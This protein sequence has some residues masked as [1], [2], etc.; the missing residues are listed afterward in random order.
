MERLLRVS[1]PPKISSSFFFARSTRALFSPSAQRIASAK[2]DLPDPLGP[3]IAVMPGANS[4]VVLCTN[5]LNPVTV[6]VLNTALGALTPPSITFSSSSF[7]C[8]P[9]AATPPPRL[10]VRRAS[11]PHCR[12]RHDHP[13]PLQRRIRVDAPAQSRRAP[14]SS[15]V[16]D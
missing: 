12:A 7:T 16:R 9:R 4:R 6:S 3:M 2:F 1:D 14:D 10:P 8:S 15:A 11:T 5:D 13:L